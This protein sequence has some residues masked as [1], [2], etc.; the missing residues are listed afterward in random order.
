[1][2]RLDGAQVLPQPLRLAQGEPDVALEVP[3][4]VGAEAQLAGD[5]RDAL[6]LRQRLAE[7]AVVD[8]LLLLPLLAPGIPKELDESDAGAAGP[9]PGAPPA[10]APHKLFNEGDGFLAKGDVARDDA[11]QDL[12]GQG[13]GGDALVQERDADG[14]VVAQRHDAADQRGVGADDPADADAG[15]AVGLGEG[16]GADGALVAE[17]DERRGRRGRRVAFVVVVVVVEEQGGEDLVGEERDV[18]LAGEITDLLQLVLGKDG[19][20][21]VV[22]VAGFPGSL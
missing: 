17:G 19:P 14:G 4:A 13:E 11:G 9:Y 7:G 2:E 16:A 18:V 8:G 12:G 15:E 1:M 10:A 20:R 6:A 21:R 22:G 3:A 5:G